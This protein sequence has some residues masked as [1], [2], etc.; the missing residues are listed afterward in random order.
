MKLGV[1]PI[2]SKYLFY[3]FVSMEIIKDNQG[4]TAIH[5]VISIWGKT[6]IKSLLGNVGNNEVNNW[7]L[8]HNH[9][10]LLY[11]WLVKQS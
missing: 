7:K 10:E 2:I 4:H 9:S 1:I 3:F 11:H 8:D 5:Y 6:D